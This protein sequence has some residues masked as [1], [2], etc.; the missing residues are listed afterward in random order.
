MKLKF[1]L[2]ETHDEYMQAEQLQRTVWGFADREVIPLSEL[3]VA[4]KNGGFVFGA[5]D[6]Q[7]KM[8]GF[9][10][11]VP[12]Y[13]DGQ[14]YHYSRMLGVLPEYQ[15]KGL[16]H[17]LKLMQRQLVQDQGLKLIR[18]T[19]DPLQ[20]RN[21]FFNI[22]KLG[23]IVRE[24]GINVYG[25]ASSSRF[26]EGLETDRFIPEW[27]INSKRVREKL[28]ARARGTAVDEVVLWDKWKP[29][30]ETKFNSDGLL[31]PE[32]TRLNHKSKCVAVEI[33]DNIGDIKRRSLELAQEWRFETRKVF[34]ALFDKGYTV[35]GFST[36]LVGKKR[37]SFYLLEKDYKI[38]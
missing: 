24:Y 14:L 12:G 37:H 7:N 4:Q 5:F 11:G 32:T 26:N 25:T 15:D 10:F 31:E 30:I 16:G 1:K 20:S 6:S 8:V 19:F 28:G 35:T 18:W 17:E 36:G 29:A 2:L 33:P 9:C 3:V 13:K 34:T 38:K 22:E 23:V 27:W 21:A